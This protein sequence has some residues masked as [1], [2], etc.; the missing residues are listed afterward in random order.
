M[1]LIFTTIGSA[2]DYGNFGRWLFFTLTVICWGAQFASMSLTCKH[3]SLNCPFKTD[4][5][6]VTFQAPDR[7]KA[8]M[9]LYMIGFISYG[10]TLV[11]YAAIFPKLARNTPHARNL[12][13][14]YEAGE[15]SAEEYEREESLEKNRISNIS[16]VCN[17]RLNPSFRRL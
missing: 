2:A 11:F 17:L 12:R 14:K 3:R 13:E 8:A 1:T 6:F 5:S 10:A 9:A 16:T 15:V 7:W 4:S